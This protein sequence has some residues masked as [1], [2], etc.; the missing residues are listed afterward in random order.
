M[1]LT[2][3]LLAAA[4]DRF[5]DM[6]HPDDNRPVVRPALPRTARRLQRKKV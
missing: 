6:E 1:R 2:E 3:W 5:D 4:K